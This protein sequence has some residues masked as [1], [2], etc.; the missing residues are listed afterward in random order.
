[1]CCLNN[2]KF[3]LSFQPGD[4]HDELRQGNNY[5]YIQVKKG[6]YAT[7][8]M[9]G[10]KLRTESNTSS[11]I[12]DN[13]YDNILC[14]PVQY[15]VPKRN[16]ILE[17]EIGSGNF[18]CVFKGYLKVR[19]G[20]KVVAVKM[21]KGLC[22]NSLESLTFVTSTSYLSWKL[23]INCRVYKKSNN[24]Y[25]LTFYK[26]FPNSFILLSTVPGST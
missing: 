16:V 20:K 23:S 22:F 11:D 25:P 10:T 8:S 15:E 3:G 6:H 5:A 12:L 18:G 19:S 4:E 2:S 21:L 1:M 13:E 9:T 17:K 24:S 7:Q 14:Q 26:I